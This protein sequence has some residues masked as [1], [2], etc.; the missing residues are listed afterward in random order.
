MWPDVLIVSGNCLYLCK[1]KWYF[2]DYPL[3]FLKFLCFNT[4]II[5]G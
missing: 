5:V 4:R 2:P 3:D 1:K